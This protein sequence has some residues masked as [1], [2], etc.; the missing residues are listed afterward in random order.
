MHNRLL[1]LAQQS[2]SNAQDNLAR[3][4]RAAIE[5]DPAEKW[6]ESEQTLEQIIAGYEKREAEAQELVNKL[7]CEDNA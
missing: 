3:A 6:G 7:R 5:C 4:K 1:T 2:L